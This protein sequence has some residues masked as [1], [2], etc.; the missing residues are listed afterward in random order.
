MT[1]ECFRVILHVTHLVIC[2]LVGLMVVDLHVT[3]SSEVGE[4]LPLNQTW[5]MESAGF[6]SRTFRIRYCYEEVIWLITHRPFIT[7]KINVASLADTMSNSDNSII[8]FKS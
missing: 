1:N 5:A 6:R 4:R 3:E 2:S 8:D 7:Y